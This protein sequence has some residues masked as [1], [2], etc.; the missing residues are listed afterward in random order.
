MSPTPVPYN[1]IT[2]SNTIRYNCN[3]I[4]CW[5]NFRYC[6]TI[7]SAI[8]AGPSIFDNKSHYHVNCKCC[9]KAKRVEG[10]QVHMTG[11]LNSLIDVQLSLEGGFQS[12]GDNY[13][14]VI[15]LTLTTPGRWSFKVMNPLDARL[16]DGFPASKYKASIRILKWRESKS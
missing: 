16:E 9:S 5:Y 10:R 4:P 7:F 12:T 3:I 6:N 14:S 13:I 15:N 1:S 2:V 11:M 8:I